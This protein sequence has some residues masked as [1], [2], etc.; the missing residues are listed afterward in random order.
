MSIP[1]LPLRCLYVLIVDIAFAVP[2]VETAL[3]ALVH[4]HV[5]EVLIAL[6]DSVSIK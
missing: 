6:D 5:P 3:V 4:A 2:A 1:V